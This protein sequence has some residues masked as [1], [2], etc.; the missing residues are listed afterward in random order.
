MIVQAYCSKLGVCVP[1]QC[2]LT[3]AQPGLACPPAHLTC[4]PG[5]CIQ[6]QCLSLVLVSKTNN[7]NSGKQEQEQKKE[8]HEQKPERPTFFQEEERTTEPFPIP[9]LR[10]RRSAVFDE[11]YFDFRRKR[12]TEEEGEDWLECPAGTS[13]CLQQQRCTADCR[14]DLLVTEQ[15]Q[16]AGQE[17]E[18]EGDWESCRPGTH[19]CLTAMRCVPDCQGDV[20]AGLEE[21]GGE[22][23]EEWEGEEV[24]CPVGSVYCMETGG[25]SRDCGWGE[26]GEEGE[27]EEGAGPGWQESCPA[28]QVAP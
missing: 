25:C 23:E 26:E 21:E 3:Q 27:A 13:Y 1:E 20:G 18:Q 8:N 11:G 12:Q 5:L 15:Q 4:G 2:Q 6:T 9:E 14:A 17:G 7:R 16:Q 24:V 22:P 10:K 28:G 19:F